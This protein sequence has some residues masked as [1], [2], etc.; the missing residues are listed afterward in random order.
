MAA[1]SVASLRVV[2]LESRWRADSEQRGR[3]ARQFLVAPGKEPRTQASSP[4]LCPCR[5]RSTYQCILA[6]LSPILGET[7]W[8][9]EERNFPFA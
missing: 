9:V 2:V 3:Q 5:Q 7:L 6:P 4:A 8:E 1:Y